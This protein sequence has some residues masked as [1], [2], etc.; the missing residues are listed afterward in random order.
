MY[1]DEVA[2]LSVPTPSGKSSL[3]VPVSNT[4]FVYTVGRAMSFWPVKNGN[5]ATWF[6]EDISRLYA[7]GDDENLTFR[8]K[9]VN[10]DHTVGQGRKS[11]VV[12]VTTK[13]KYIPGVGVDVL[14]QLD[15]RL[16]EEHGIT[17]DDFGKDGDYSSQSVEINCDRSKSKFIVMLK[18][19][20]TNIKDQ[21]VYS[22]EEALSMGIRR[23]QLH[24]GF[25]V[26]EAC[27][28]RRVRGVAMTGSPADTTAQV[29]DM[30]ASKDNTVDVLAAKPAPNDTY[31]D[32]SALDESY[33]KTQPM[34]LSNDDTN[35]LDDGAFAVVQGGEELAGTAP[36]IRKR[37]LPL[38][39]SNKHHYSGIPHKGLIKAALAGIGPDKD[40][41][42]P[43]PQAVHS[44]ALQRV[45]TAHQQL[46]GDYSM[47]ITAEEIAAIKDPLDR[48]IAE[49]KE[50]IRV[51]QEEK[52]TLGTNVGLKDDAIALKDT[53]IANLKAENKALKDAADEAAAIVVAN[54]RLA[55]LVKVEGFAVA[56]TEKAVLIVA[57][58]AE[59]EDQFK[60]RLLKEENASLERRLKAGGKSA[61]DETASLTLT[62]EHAGLRALSGASV[63]LIANSAQAALYA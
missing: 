16:L 57:L 11:I 53:E 42:R 50:Q 56:D 47:A 7:T 43:Y 13:E 51:A 40:G 24:D 37:E 6:E 39:E 38:Y 49:L 55:E 44:A 45:R 58:A 36:S 29:F 26:V 17:P 63:K 14:N 4:E 25:K 21:K 5:D 19:N 31:D 28:P 60:N 10:L 27:I 41:K 62:D 54:T 15:R 20:S 18:P 59:N 46:T 61:T 34:S 22:A 8:G 1:E 30:A 32:S 33:S 9:I 3:S 35:G 2:I 12:G 52:A 23:G 48:S